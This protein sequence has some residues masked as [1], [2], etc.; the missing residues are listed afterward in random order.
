[1]ADKDPGDDG[2]SLEMPTLGSLLRRKKGR[3]KDEASTPKPDSAP[4]PGPDAGAAGEPT[5]DLAP[6]AEEFD[7]IGRGKRSSDAA[8][9]AAGSPVDRAPTEA[10]PAAPAD[11]QDTEQTRPLFADETAVDTPRAAGS[12][13]EPERSPDDTASTEVLAAESPRA[14]RTD[15][16]PTPKREAKPK[17][18]PKPKREFTLPPIA[19]RLAAAITGAVVGLLAVAL[20]YLG[21]RGCEAVQG[22]SSCGSPG[23]V[24]LL[25]IMIGLIVIGSSLLGAWR[26]PDAPSTSFLAVGLLAVVALLFL[27]EVIFSVWMILVI[28]LVSIATFCLSQWVTSLILDETD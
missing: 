20:T 7:A 22:T 23:F 18:E 2:P 15:P 19:A 1:M 27:I 3:K 16:A 17:R 11:A 21:L 26:V 25:A 14:T 12:D 5:D 10:P 24:L 4:D 13:T 9:E 6:T 8:E 28:P